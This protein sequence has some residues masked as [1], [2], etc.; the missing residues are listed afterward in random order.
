MSKQSDAKAAQGYIAKA[1]PQTCGN[2]KHFQFERV[3]ANA[4]D[5][6]KPMVSEYWVDANLRC[7]IGGFAVKKLG[8]CQSFVIKSA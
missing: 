5:M 8:T 2:C 6:G 3:N 7:G 4:A 1:V